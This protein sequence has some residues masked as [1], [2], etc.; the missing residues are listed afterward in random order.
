MFPKQQDLLVWVV[1]HTLQD[2]HQMPPREQTQQ[3]ALKAEK[4]MLVLVLKQFYQ[5]QP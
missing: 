1:D 3:A 5:N 4:T 2:L